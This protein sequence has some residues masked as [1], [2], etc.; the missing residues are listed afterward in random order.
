MSHSIT[1]GMHT[2]KDKGEANIVAGTSA[3]DTLVGTAADDRITGLAGDDKLSD[4]LGGSD[5]LIGGAGDDIITVLRSDKASTDKIHID[6]G[7]GDDIISYTGAAANQVVLDIDGGSGDNTIVANKVFDGHILGGAGADT[8]TISTDGHAVVHTAGG[9]DVINASS[10]D[11]DARTGIS[12]GDGQ[13]TIN[14]DADD[15]GHFRMRLGDGADAITLGASTD[16]SADAKLV[17]YDFQ[18]GDDGDQVNFDAYLKSVLTHGA[19]GDPFADHHLQLFDG[20]TA[21][22]QAA[23]IL[24]MDVDG[25]KNGADWV[26]LAVFVGVT[27]DDLTSHNLGGLDPVV[28]TTSDPD[29]L[30]V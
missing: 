7:T 28:T 13:D 20:V 26:K 29:A 15:S 23:A 1:D 22:G 17:F 8:V 25:D 11:A 24:E 4:A 6:G 12:S 19:G 5:T 2:L 18:A 30:V 10:V 9:D 27:A 3:G 16:G 21:G 14:L